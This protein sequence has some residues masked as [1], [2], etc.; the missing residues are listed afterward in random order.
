MV[1]MSRSYSLLV[2]GS[3]RRSTCFVSSYHTA[4]SRAVGARGTG[5]MTLGRQLML[6]AVARGPGLTETTAYR[7]ESSA[8][9]APP[10]P[11]CR[12]VY[13]MVTPRLARRRDS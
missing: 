11:G 13:V 3:R 8:W 5:R 10:R 2:A 6:M 1:G 9:I 12:L 7:E 4:T